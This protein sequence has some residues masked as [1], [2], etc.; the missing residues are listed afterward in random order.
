MTFRIEG[1]QRRGDG[2]DCAPLP[3]SERGV[4][5]ADLAIFFLALGLGDVCTGDAWNLP[6][7]GTGAGG[8][9]AGQGLVRWCWPVLIRCIVRAH[10][11]TS[12][13][14]TLSAPP[15]PL[16]VF[17]QDNSCVAL[18]AS[19]LAVTMLLHCEG[20]SCSSARRRL[21]RR[22]RSWAKHERMSIAIAL[23]E[24]PHTTIARRWRATRPMVG[25]EVCQG[26]WLSPWCLEGS[27]GA[28]AQGPQPLCV[29]IVSFAGCFAVDR[30]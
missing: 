29:C 11:Q 10:G 4:R 22:L 9:P 1:I 16:R 24:N 5:W 13:G 21:E 30:T 3:P 7:K 17:A 8:F 28:V 12:A 26:S 18:I 19:P 27:R 23:A 15:P 6:S 20:A 2:K 25:T 14:Y